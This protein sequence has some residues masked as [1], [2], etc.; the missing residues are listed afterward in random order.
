MAA[1][2]SSS[3]WPHEPVGSA[4][5]ACTNLLLLVVGALALRLWSVAAS[6]LSRELRRRQLT[7]Y[8]VA[9]DGKVGSTGAIVVH[10]LPRP[11]RP[12]S[13]LLL[14]CL[15]RPGCG[16]AGSYPTAEGHRAQLDIVAVLQLG[17]P[18]RR[19]AQRAL[20]EKW[21]RRIRDCQDA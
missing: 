6:D 1:L 19:A 20:N 21:A 10:G 2:A 18:G 14:G 9:V 16:Y 11:Q 12:C 4:W 13:S 3:P 5:L 15:K 8:G 17:L 7:S